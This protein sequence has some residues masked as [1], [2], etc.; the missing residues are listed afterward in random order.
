MEEVHENFERDEREALIRMQTFR[1]NLYHVVNYI[2]FVRTRE[3]IKRRILKSARKSQ[4]DF[5][6]RKNQGAKHSAFGGSMMLRRTTSHVREELI[7]ERRGVMALPE[8]D[9]EQ[10]LLMVE[11]AEGKTMLGELFMAAFWYRC[12]RSKTSR[13]VRRRRAR[14]A[15]ARE[16]IYDWFR[17]LKILFSGD[18]KQILANNSRDRL[19]ARMWPTF[20][21]A[22]IHFWNARAGEL[23]GQ[24]TPGERGKFE[25]ATRVAECLSRRSQDGG[26][27]DVG[28][29]YQTIKMNQV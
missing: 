12:S 4:S 20:L 29:M 14:D 5:W 13:H 11:L 1:R 22:D 28:I 9:H 23:L 15:A 10:A 26:P 16:P 25:P 27:D 2:P 7:G 18:S 3:W 19:S 8:I 24:E 17:T 6:I 21:E